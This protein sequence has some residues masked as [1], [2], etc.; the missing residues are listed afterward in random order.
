MEI[1]VYYNI[2]HPLFKRVVMIPDAFDIK[3]FVSCMKAVF[4]DKVCVCIIYS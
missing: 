1:S 3:A 4:G 2:E